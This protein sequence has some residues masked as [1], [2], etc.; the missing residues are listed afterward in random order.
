MSTAPD[1]IYVDSEGWANDH[2][3]LAAKSPSEGYPDEY[4][5]ATPEREAAGEMREALELLRQRINVN[6]YGDRGAYLNDAD[7]R[8]MILALASARGEAGDN[9]RS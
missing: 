4:L 5:L 7:C 3:R 1:R 8:L 2:Y 6:S 9:A